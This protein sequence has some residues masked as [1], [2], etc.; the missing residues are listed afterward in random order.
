[1]VKIEIEDV[2]YPSGKLYWRKPSDLEYDTLDSWAEELR[3]DM[4]SEARERGKEE[5]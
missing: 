4:L 3:E 2:S 1:M 5:I